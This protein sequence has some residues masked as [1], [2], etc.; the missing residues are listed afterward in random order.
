MSVIDIHPSLTP[1]YSISWGWVS[2]QLTASSV[3]YSIGSSIKSQ[4]K[5]PYAVPSSEFVICILGI[6]QDVTFYQTSFSVPLTHRDRLLSKFRNY[7][8]SG[9]ESS[10]PFSTDRKPGHPEVLHGRFLETTHCLSMPLQGRLL[11]S[12]YNYRRSFFLLV[13]HM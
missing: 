12:A 9:T 2:L 8:P 1:T 6:I 3:R 7:A 5:T 11:R 4:A 13:A 10:V